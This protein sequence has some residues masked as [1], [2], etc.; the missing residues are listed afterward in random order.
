MSDT[1]R[2]EFEFLRAVQRRIYEL[3]YAPPPWPDVVDDIDSAACMISGLLA[4]IAELEH[5]LRHKT[6]VIEYRD[7][8]IAELE[9]KK[10][11][12]RTELRRLNKYLGPYWSGFRQGITRE[13]EVRLR[14]IMNAAFGRQAVRA[15]EHNAID[16][17]RAKEGK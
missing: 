12:Q 11:N 6:E 14:G 16:A 1:P 5:M 4:R 17:A 9:K 10:N 2:I 8:Y 7:L 15:A 3:G 13:G